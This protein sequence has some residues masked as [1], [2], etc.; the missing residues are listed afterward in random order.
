[1]IRQVGDCT[2]SIHKSLPALWRVVH[3]CIAL[4]RLA[5]ENNVRRRYSL[6]VVES[7][8]HAVHANSTLLTNHRTAVPVQSACTEYREHALAANF[9]K[10]ACQKVNSYRKQYISPFLKFHMRRSKFLKQESP[11]H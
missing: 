4:Y 11:C 9:L 10:S 8:Q 1:M 3:V 7:D 6:R 5:L 2:L